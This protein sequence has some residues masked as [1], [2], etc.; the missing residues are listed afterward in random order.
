MICVVL[1]EETRSIGVAS[2]L[3]PACAVNLEYLSTALEVRRREGHEPYFSLDPV[4]SDQN[5]MQE[6]KFVPEW[7]AGTSAGDV[8]FQADYHLKE[9]SMGEYEQPVVGMKSCFDISELEKD[10]TEWSAR[11]WFM[12]RKAEMLISD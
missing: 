8:L 9:L 2:T 7:L 12:V 3:E 1:D 6:K 11:E 5:A 10:Q 4:S